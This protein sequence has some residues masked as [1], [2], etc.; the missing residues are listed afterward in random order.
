MTVVGKF[1]IKSSDDM[2]ATMEIEMTIGEWKHVKMDLK[3]RS[4]SSTYSATE[5]LEKVVADLIT[6]SEGVFH[7]REET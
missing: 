7:A 2:V 6:R 3:R 1:Q 4:T 5:S